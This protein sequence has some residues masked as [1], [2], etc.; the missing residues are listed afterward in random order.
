MK[1]LAQKDKY[2]IHEIIALQLE[3]I[4]FIQEYI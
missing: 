3:F 4:D 2:E 1:E